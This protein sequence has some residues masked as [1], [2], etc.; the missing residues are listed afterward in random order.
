MNTE[1]I[2]N[3]KKTVRRIIKEQKQANSQEINLLK[4]EIIFSKIELL[5]QFIPAKVVLAYWS[6]PDE[7]TTHNFIKKWSENKQFALPIIV[8]ENLELRLFSDVVKMKQASSFGILEPQTGE[9][10]SPHD[11]D[12]AIIPGIAFDY[13]GNRLG[14]GKGYYDRILNQIKGSKVG[15]GFDFQ[16]LD[17]VPISSFDVP[18]D[19]VISN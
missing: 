6:L 8:G 7:V 18:V 14:R 3:Q 19:I 11:I 10:M 16:I 15:V 12:F 17:F 4:S 5:P 1:D 13:K 9:L 2:I